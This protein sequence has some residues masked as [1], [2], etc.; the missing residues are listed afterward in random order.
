[1]KPSTLRAL[2][3]TSLVLASGAR[4]PG[5]AAADWPQFNLDVR[6]S[7]SSLQESIIHAGNVATL[8][9]RYH[10]ALPGGAVA[11]G[12]PAF[13]AGVATPQGTRDL[14]FLNTRGG[15]LLAL[16]AAT[17]ALLWSQQPAASP[18]ITTSSPAIDPS[19]GFVYAYGLDGKVHKYQV[20]DGTEILTGG[21][22]EVAT[23]KP[24]VEKGSAALTIA[25][26]AGGTSYLYV[27]SSGYVAKTGDYQ[28]H[29]TTV[30]L[31]TGTQ[32]VFNAMCSDQ[33]VHFVAAPGTPD[34]A[35]TQSGVWGRAGVVYEPEKDTI[36]F[37][38]GAGTFDANTGGHDWG[39]S[40]LA[41]H[42]DGTGA[43]G[44]PLDAYTPNDYAQ[45][46]NGGDLGS[47]A[48]AILHPVPAS[49]KIA[50]LA[51]QLA[52]EPEIHLISLDDMSG[53]GGPGHTGGEVEPVAVP[54]G[55]AT[56]T[57]PAVWFNPQNATTWSFI[58]NDNGLAAMQ[59]FVDAAGNPTIF[60]Q[61]TK[62]NGGT[63]PVLANGILFYAGSG[64]VRALDPASGNQLWSDTS[65]GPLH[66]QSPI[67]VGGRLYITDENAVLWAYEPAP[68][69]LGFYTLPPC[70]LL[71]TRTAS[72][73]YGG[74]ALAGG[75]PRTFAVAGQCGVPS[76][77]QAIAANL[78]VVA[79]S[80][81][82]HLEATPAN[83]VG[84]T[85]AIN[86]SSGQVRAN[87]AVLSLTGNPLG[88]LTITAGLVGGAGAQTDV[89]LDVNGYFK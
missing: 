15:T 47:S 33:A 17:G 41:L 34:C 59:L 3:V 12:A 42:P 36:F 65:I 7:G 81:A 82:G 30:N 61:W 31:A 77:A 55:G 20:G 43:N 50:H 67:V 28:G 2:T 45:L 6:H 86:F 62:M 23:L 64:V 26:A 76:D 44:G 69:P 35:Q 14:L 66:W 11:D 87:N 27:A 71:D 18:G 8:H 56:L 58:A 1:M 40:V 70:R 16:D 25:T 49:S 89:V 85:S 75:S 10:V 9:A 29:V 73:P 39:D 79:P 24:D 72:G 5:A 60:S 68:A 52:K 46:Q 32:T 38:T 21:W 37:A 84:A 54:Q 63:S 53:K 80:S 19:R 74:P 57:A 78:T 51:I 88:S 13:L 83:V 48:P 4:P 22:P